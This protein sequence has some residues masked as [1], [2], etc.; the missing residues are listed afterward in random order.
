MPDPA[1]SSLKRNRLLLVAAV[2]LT[3]IV[4]LG[5]GYA[6]RT[7]RVAAQFRLW[8]AEGLAAHAAG[9]RPV[10]L[11]L[12]GR[13][14]ARHPDDEPALIAYA[15]DRPL[16]EEPNNLHLVQ[17]VQALRSLLNLDPGLVPQQ[18]QLLRLYEQTGYT[19]EALGLADKI[20]ATAP[21][22]PDALA[23]RTAALVRTHRLNDALTAD[24]AWCAA[25][26]TSVPARLTRLKLIHDCRLPKDQAVRLAEGWARQ[27]SSTTR[28]AAGGAVVTAPTDPVTADL[29]RGHARA[30]YLDLG[31]AVGPLKAAAAA[32]VAAHP[33][34]PQAT[35][36]ALVRDLDGVRQ[37]DLARAL[38]K[39]RFRD[40][41]DDFELR[42]D[43]ARR[44]FEAGLYQDAASRL[45]GVGE[46]AEVPSRVLGLRAVALSKLGRT[47]EVAPIR[48]ALRARPPGDDGTAAAWA[49]VVTTGPDGTYDPAAVAAAAGPVLARANDPLLRFILGEAYV[50]LGE[51]DLA[52][53]QWEQVV[54][55][56]LSWAEPAILLCRLLTE[57]GQY[58]AALSAGVEA[59]ERAPTDGEAQIALA[60]AWGAS[61]QLHPGQSPGR[62]VELV[63]T[64]AKE[65][66]GDGRIPPIR[67]GLMLALNQPAKAATVI[68]AALD[69]KQKYPADTW[70]RLAGLSRSADLHL[71]QACVDREQQ[72]GGLTPAVAYAKAAAL[73]TAG[74]GPD[75]L[76]SFDADHAA[77]AATV[78]PTTAAAAGGWD[79]ARAR[80]LNLTHD[81]AAPAAWRAL[82]DAHPDDLAV[83]R[84]ALWS[85]CVL[86]DSAALD[87]AVDRLG[88][89]VPRQGTEYQLARA[90][91]LV[92]FGTTPA[93]ASE[94]RTDLDDVLAN[95]PN[96]VEARLLSAQAHEAAGRLAEA[97]TDM[98]A[99][100]DLVPRAPALHLAVA[101]LLQVQGD[102]DG[103]RDQLRG[104][105]PDQLAAGE[106]RRQA[107]VLLEQNGQTDRAIALLEADRGGTDAATAQL[108]LADLYRRRGDVKRAQAISDRLLAEHPT[109]V[110]VQFGAELLAA[111][112]RVADGRRLLERL[113]D[114]ALPG[115]GNGV[116]ELA[117]G[118]F[119]L[120]HDADDAGH[121][122][123]RAR[124]AAATAAGPTNPVTW[125]ARVAADLL[126]GH[127][128][129]AVAAARSGLAAL[130]NDAALLG[131]VRDADALAYAA[132]RPDLRPLLLPFLHDPAAG[133]APSVTLDTLR[134]ADV[135]HLPLP[136][137][138]G[139]LNEL[140]ARFPQFVPLYLD[141]VRLDGQIGR[142]ADAADVAARAAQADPD[143]AAVPP[144]RTAVL[145]RLGRWP[146]VVATA[147]RWR[148]HFPAD[149]L[150][151]DAAAADAL[152]HLDRPAEAAARVQPYADGPGRDRVLPVLARARLAGGEADPSAVM[153]PLLA[154]G[155][156]GRLA[157][158][159][160]AAERLPPPRA[161]NWI[162]RAVAAMPADAPDEHADAAEAYDRLADRA[163]GPAAARP[164]VAAGLDVLRP[165]LAVAA[166]AYR[167]LWE[168]ASDDERLDD[169]AAAIALYRRMLAAAPGDI[170]AENNLA[171]L[172]A[173]GG[174]AAEAEPLVDA[175]VAARPDVADLHDTRAF[176]L[177]HAGRPDQA[178]AAEA[179]A[180]RL[181]PARVGFRVRQIGL[182]VDARRPADA[183]EAL[184]ALDAVRFDPAAVDP[185]TRDQLRD[186][187]ARLTKG[188]TTA[189]GVAATPRV[190]QP[191]TLS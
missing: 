157:W 85:P 34:P 17:A 176:V 45:D 86:A 26:P 186:L 23:A 109:A 44:D 183:T 15:A 110:A 97:T 12:L 139:R 63:D 145:A 108:T 27:W 54:G 134:S 99:A 78:P 156:A 68:R 49:T 150:A 28:P 122:R 81:P 95:N 10:A 92:T 169:P 188:P 131:V 155:P 18:R 87:R 77:A 14:L 179:V 91:W 142:D 65:A 31:G 160:F 24:Q 8:R 82:T 184:R 56:D 93:Q 61:L 37:P 140:T 104:V 62:S 128:A 25:D 168:A 147:D 143:D 118:N 120:E 119:A 74:R 73:A 137:L 138:A 180:I 125:R 166:P 98:R 123:A 114:P 6:Y 103:A 175:A 89:L 106:Q 182:L 116:A 9:N 167:V 53:R 42:L 20:L 129:D 153:E 51:R 135:N 170:N 100:V 2:F 121:A 70:E 117:R 7:R 163:A 11:D 52:V 3:G 46:S 80:Y 154:E 84:A 174:Q 55:D 90:R 126:T 181:D 113:S 171:M 107:A 148:E 130:P 47:A 40:D 101:H 19:T 144:V 136:E 158:M 151:A 16:V 29:F 161:G 132:A 178:L 177:A 190:D 111:T 50:R 152:L 4:V 173:R 1:R 57:T 43:L 191:I 141:L 172:L 79:L 5:G 36:A 94:A 102:F 33:A 75:G 38:V 13:Y 187:R 88:K 71:E 146:D 124:F 41:P 66:P 159:R 133:S 30:V 22:D 76:K 162:R 105:D 112:G 67:A 69:G 32:A 48:R 83:Q 127:A 21:A 165:D 164:W 189:P 64:L 35:L 185:E 72:D 96:S 149:A 58:D 39:A 115:T 60:A 59:A